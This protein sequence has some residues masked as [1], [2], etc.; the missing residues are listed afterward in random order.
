MCLNKKTNKLITIKIIKSQHKT[1]KILT[2][3]TTTL[4]KSKA[5]LSSSLLQETSKNVVS[6]W[7]GMFQTPANFS[8]LTRAAQYENS[9]FRIKW[10]CKWTCATR[11]TRILP[12]KSNILVL[13]TW[14]QAAVTARSLFSR[15]NSALST[16]YSNSTNPMSWPCFTT[17]P[18]KLSMPR[19]VTLK[20]FVCSLLKNLTTQIWKRWTVFKA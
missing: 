9:T 19:A 7:R 20:S 2:I 14:F 3:I 16:R 11:K 10:L 17:Q 13:D 4:T 1:K 12:G 8:L 15:R 18:S 6:E 5:I